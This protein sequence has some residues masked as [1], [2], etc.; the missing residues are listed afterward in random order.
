MLTRTRFGVGLA[1][2]ALALTACSG[3]SGASASAEASDAT[4]AAASGDEAPP[5]DG[6]PPDGEA[7]GDGA[8][9]GGGA[10]VDTGTGAY[11]L[12]DGETL[13]GGTYSSEGDDENAIRAEGDISAA[14]ESVT[15]EKTGGGS[16]SSDASSFYGLNAAILALDGADL[17]IDGGTVTATAEG[18]NGVLAYGGTI[19]I[20]DTVIDV[21]G[22]NAGGIEVAG[23]GTLYATD[24]T[25]NATVKA[26]IRSDRGGGTL[27]VEGGTYTT[28]G[29]TGAPAIYS[30]ADISVSDATLV[31]EDSEA[32][33]VEG[34]NSVS[35]T[36]S[37]V[38]GAMSA[39]AD[40]GADEQLQNVMLYQSMSGDAEEGT[41]S[42]TMSGGSLT[43]LSGDMFYVTNTDAVIS[44]SGVALTLA[45]GTDL[46]VVAGNDGSRGW[47]TEGANGGTATVDLAG[48]SA[49]GDIVV[50]EISEL[51][52]S[53]TGGSDY[54][55]A[56][57]PDGTAAAALA[58]DLDASSTW[59]LTGD[60]YVTA[61]TGSLDGIDLDGYSLY[62]D[63]ALY[64]P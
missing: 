20:S 36:D 2:M 63:G 32:V 44:L 57:N 38:T 42:F 14:L 23:G 6:A 59:T 13:D 53:L 50:D 10:E 25:V 55:G 1:A 7:P 60:S 4:L 40:G 26:A 21:S 49:S 62:V 15:V 34:L 47:G 46:L 24:L 43:S 11:V 48:Q 19:T 52:L 22:G 35:I 33:V 5:G 29:S 37:D 9:P 56:V 27:V 18:A 28:S 41:S 45:D 31:S 39:S 61:L 30:T 12:A 51:T 17:T 54:T 16:S 3:T 8:A 64:T 58:V